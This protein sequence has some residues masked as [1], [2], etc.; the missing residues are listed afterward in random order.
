M[1]TYKITRPELEP[2]TY[3]NRL[4]QRQTGWYPETIRVIETGIDYVV[5]L[6][7]EDIDDAFEWDKNNQS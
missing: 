4:C 2:E 3:I 5:Y 6:C 7:F 1:N